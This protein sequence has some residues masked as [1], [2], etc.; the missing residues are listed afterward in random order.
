MLEHEMLIHYRMICPLPE[1]DI[2]N[3]SAFQALLR[4]RRGQFV[5]LTTLCHPDLHATE[6]SYQTLV[7]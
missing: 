5:L 2:Q 6:P 4:S 7:R 1:P 3:T